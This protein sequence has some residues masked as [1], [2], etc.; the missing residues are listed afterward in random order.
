MGLIKMSGGD[1]QSNV[2][3]GVYMNGKRQYIEE[4]EHLHH[5]HFVVFHTK[6][7]VYMSLLRIHILK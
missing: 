7:C 3:K 1:V 6:K 2:K 5:A 4:L